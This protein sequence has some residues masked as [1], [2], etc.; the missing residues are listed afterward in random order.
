MVARID[1]AAIGRS[2]GCWTGSMW[3][4]SPGGSGDVE[5]GSRLLKGRGS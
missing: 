5:I 3:D 4:I 1:V 2:G